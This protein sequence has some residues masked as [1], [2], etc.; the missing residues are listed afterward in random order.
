MGSLQVFRLMAAT[1]RPKHREVWN[2]TLLPGRHSFLRLHLYHPLSQTG[3]TGL[4][5]EIMKKET[6]L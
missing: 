3:E 6:R 4:A 1:A 5:I 2:W